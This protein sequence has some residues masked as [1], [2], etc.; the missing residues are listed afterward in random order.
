MLMATDPGDLVLDPTCGS[1]TTAYVAEQWGRRWIT[2]D[3]SRVPLALARQRL[4]TATFPYYELKDPNRGPAGGFVYKRRQNRKGEEVGGRVPHITLKSIANDEEP[5]MDVLVDRPEVLKGTTRVTGPFT[6][7]ATIPAASEV[8][9]AGESGTRDPPSPGYTTG[10]PEAHIERMLEVLRRSETLHLLGNEAPQLTNIRRLAD[11]EHLHAAASEPSE[12]GRRVAVVFGPEDGAISSDVVFE[13]ARE[14]YFLK[15]DQLFFFGFAIQAKARE[16]IGD[17]SKLRIPCTY[18]AVTPDVVMSDLLKTTRASEIFSVTG[19]PA[20]R[21]AGPRR[22]PSTDRPST[23]WSCG[24]WTSSTR[25][26]WRPRPSRAATFRPGCW[27]RSTTTS[28][29]TRLRYFF[30]GPP[31][32]TISRNP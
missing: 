30:P 8:A 14:A 6:V 13:A 17:K 15:Y 7:E 16:L 31:P 32:G 22:L 1:G 20:S 10:N 4:L 9:D 18:V 28:A 27:T 29:S 23:R 5:K 19:L 2:C 11:A 21:C 25:R 24:G 26:T 3:T 12:D